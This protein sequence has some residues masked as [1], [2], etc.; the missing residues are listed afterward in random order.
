MVSSIADN[1]ITITRL[2]NNMMLVGMNVFRF[3]MPQ[4]RDNASLVL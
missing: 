4:L 3:L 1:M 2:L